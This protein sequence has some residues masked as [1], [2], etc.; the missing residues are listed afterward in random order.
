MVFTPSARA[1]GQEAEEYAKDYLLKQGYTLRERNYR[2]GKGEIDLIVQKDNFL[3][4]A[5]VKIRTQTAFGYPEDFVSYTQ[6]KHYHTAAT[7]YV[8]T[9]AWKGHIR[10][11]I[12]A[13]TVENKKWDLLHLEDAFC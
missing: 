8:E 12:I 2:L 4:F 10:F 3:V 13:I 6:E 9:H 1:L 5:E 7:H 11:D